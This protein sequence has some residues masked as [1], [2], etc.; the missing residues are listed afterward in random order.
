MSRIISLSFWWRKKNIQLHHFQNIRM[1][2]HNLFIL[3]SFIMLF[4]MGD[5]DLLTFYYLLF[6]IVVFSL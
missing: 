5:S 4:S 1:A 2:G 6:T 3:I